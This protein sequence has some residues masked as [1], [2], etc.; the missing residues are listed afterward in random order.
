MSPQLEVSEYF[1]MFSELD[2]D[3]SNLGSSV[4]EYRVQKFGIAVGMN[5]LFS[6][7]RCPLLNTQVQFRTARALA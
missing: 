3:P 5:V 6:V 7:T 1:E 4:D 2:F